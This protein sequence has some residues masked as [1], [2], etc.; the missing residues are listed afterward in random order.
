MCLMR[1]R[2]I[3]VSLFFH[4]AFFALYHFNHYILPLLL[5]FSLPLCELITC[6]VP[7]VIITHDIIC[8]GN[9]SKQEHRMIKYERNTMKLSKWICFASEFFRKKNAMFII[10]LRVNYTIVSFTL[11]HICRV[12]F[13]HRFFF[14]FCIHLNGLLHY[15]MWIAFEKKKTHFNFFVV[16]QSH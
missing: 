15:W 12:F 3:F 2:F 7:M 9:A 1:I 4:N 11:G 13:S 5:F 16:F 10:I 14:L 6:H 8:K